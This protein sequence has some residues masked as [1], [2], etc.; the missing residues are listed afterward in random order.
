MTDFQDVTPVVVMVETDVGALGALI[1]DPLK[2]N[3]VAIDD[4][5]N[6]YVNAKMRGIAALEEAR[7]SSANFVSIYAAAM[8]RC[9]DECNAYAAEACVSPEDGA[10][11][12]SIHAVRVEG[13]MDDIK[14]LTDVY[15]EAGVKIDG[16]VSS[17]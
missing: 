12:V 14:K 17:V 5:S 11:M 7:N 9:C 4:K 13:V 6:F 16:E 8:L 15:M 1:D 2:L 10:E 3:Q